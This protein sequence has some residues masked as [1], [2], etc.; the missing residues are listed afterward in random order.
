MAIQIQY[1]RGS[2]SQ[3]ATDNPI[4]AIGEPG[5]ETDTGKF[6]VGNGSSAWNSLPYSSG[7]QGPTGPTG[8]QGITGPTGAI[9]ATG[10]TGDLGPTGPT[11]PFGPTG[12]QGIQ[13]I[14]GI[15]GVA[16]PTGP[17][18]PIGNTG[19][20]GPTGATPA[21]GGTNTQVQYNNAGVFAGSAN[22][23]FN[24]TAL[25]LGG[26]PT[27]TSGTA[28]G[29]AYL[30]GSKVL[31]TGSA[32]T[33]DGSAFA[34][35]GSLSATST[36]TASSGASGN[37][38]ALVTIGTAGNTVGGNG[39]QL[40]FNYGSNAA[41]RSYKIVTDSNAFGDFVIQQSTTQSGS[42]YRTVYSA[43]NDGTSL[44]SVGG[45][46]QMRLTSTGLGI[47]T[48]S[49]ESG[50]KL[51]VVGNAF[52]QPASGTVG[53][54]VVDNVDQ[55][56]VLGAYF[57]SGVGQYSFISSTNNAETGDIALR[58]RTGT[59]DRM[60]I[61]NAGDVGI[62]TS[63]P[64]TKLTVGTI[65][66]GTLEATY[67]GNIRIEGTETTIE[68]Q[69]GLEFKMT[70]DGYGAKIQT[71]SSGGT[72]L[73]FATRNASVTWTERMR[74]DP[75]GNVGIGT[76]S[77]ATKLHLATAANT[78]VLVSS[79]DGTT[80]KGIA[81]N[82]SDNQFT[83]G[84]QTN[85]PVAFFSNNTERMRIDTSGNLLVGTTTNAYIS[86]IVSNNGITDY[87]AQYNTARAGA[88][89]EFV[90][91]TSGYG[92][93]FYVNAAT[94]IATLSSAGVWTNASDAR[95]KENI[96]NSEYGLQEVLQLTPRTYNI[97]G[98][99]KKQVGFIAQE[100]IGLVPE[101]VDS[102]NNSVTQEDRYTLSYGQMSAVLV[103]AIQE[104]QAI[105]ESLKARLDAANL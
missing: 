67:K 86:K 83:V 47:G 24:G 60:T 57:E 37:S 69:G 48:S 85:H 27:I 55:R 105:I 56:L 95:Y 39:N 7:I 52:F 93:S 90:N 63:S 81:F 9:G 91:R 30:N 77:P 32:L 28:N 40:L 16:G 10:P 15:Q 104:Q 5:Y 21:I 12:P 17:T 66:A 38:I 64:S 82:T 89:Y 3:W 45:S 71:L 44:W 14:Q 26:N 25:T 88:N 94:I 78:G 50:F 79:T 100:V 72:N 76:S 4:L 6:K 1:R 84:T 2:A 99:D 23:T 75:S 42:T 29:V 54:V 19:P 46:E 101:L 68:S 49:P 43:L 92:F 103:K 51:H 102:I 11:G 13:G 59:T 20:T 36:I 96:K 31:T 97:I 8:P 61:T 41:S 53:K 58:F 62:G 33:F 35:T 73:V 98:N 18:G 65:A 70:S 34:I 87:G 22:L 80:F 74:I